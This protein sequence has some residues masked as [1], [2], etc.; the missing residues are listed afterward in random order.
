MG[1]PEQALKDAS[2]ALVKLKKKRSE[3]KNPSRAEKCSI[4]TTRIRAM[5]CKADALY[6]LSNFERASAINFLQMFLETITM[7]YWP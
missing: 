6:A 5:Q 7:Q 2:E 4:L 1:K 3:I